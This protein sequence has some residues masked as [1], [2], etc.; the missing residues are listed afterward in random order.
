M[1]QLKILIAICL[2]PL[3]VFAASEWVSFESAA[4]RFKTLF[5]RT[6][7]NTDA[8][9][10]TADFSLIM[11]AFVFD[12]SK[13]KDDN[14]MYMTA[15]CDYPDTLVSSDFKD[16]LVDEVFKGAVD[17]MAGRLGGEM[18]SVD[19]IAY[20]GYPGRNVK[21]TVKDNQGFAYVRVYLVRSRLYI[22]MVMCETP[23]EDNPS[24]NRFFNSFEITDLK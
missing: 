12:A 10:N 7:K 15:Y 3:C 4:G 19:R 6:P 22:L 14:A 18:V 2:V 23:K 13:Y 5:P 21:A 24:I 20:K 17:R 9:V 8:P 11:H 16:E 1:K